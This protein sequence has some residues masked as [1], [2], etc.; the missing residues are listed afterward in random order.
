MKVLIVGAGRVGRELARLLSEAG[1][2]VTVVDKNRER[3][4]TV[5]DVAD[6]EGIVSDVTDPEFYNKID[7][8]AFDAVIAAT[9]R[10]EVNLLV[11]A[12]AKIHGVP[13]IYVRVRVKETLRILQSLGVYDTVAEPEI[14]A[15]LMMSMI[16]GR[17]HPVILA[18]ALTGEFVLVSSVVG[19]YSPVRGRR[20][21]DVIRA[22]GL[23]GRVKVIAVYDGE[24]LMDPE[25]AG[26]MDEGYV[27]VMLALRE[28]LEDVAK[29][30]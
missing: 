18:D 20:L 14:I 27:V 17:R 7:L 11:A 10:D 5:S 26:P 13:R 1:Y 30:F 8:A 9:D 25:E 2:S 22:A 21:A 12:I 15:R 4:E 19:R 29:L 16:E 28:V 23:E 3:A 24:R 6:A